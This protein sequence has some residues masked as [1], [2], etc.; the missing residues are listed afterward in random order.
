MNAVDVD[1]M[2]RLR[3]ALMEAENDS[4]TRVVVIKGSNSTFCSGADIKSALASNLNPDEAIRVL[5]ESYG[6]TLKTIK[7]LKWPVIAAIDGAAA[8]IGL[9]LALA[10]DLRLA[11]ESALLSEL[12]IKVGLIPD[13]G[14]TWSLQRVIGQ[15]R[16]REMTFTGETIT[17]KKALEWG[18]VN[19]IIQIETFEEEVFNYASTIARQS[20]DA[21]MYG[22]KAIN[23]AANGTF[24][25]ALQREAEY[26][27]EIFKGKWGFEG[28]RAFLEKRRPGW[29]DEKF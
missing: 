22:K 3:E 13:G 25:E 5:Q 9:D 6:P 10:C 28:F 14:G 20:P 26:Q 15:A 17:A 4:I 21:L 24:E 23:E 29:M 27:E 18:L 19:R 7:N 16:A 11:S 2:N 12:F 8:G 1:C